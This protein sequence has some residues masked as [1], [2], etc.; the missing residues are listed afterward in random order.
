[1]FFVGIFGIDQRK[2]EIGTYNNAVCPACRAFTRLIIYKSYSCFH[3]F[4]IPT[5]KWNEKYYAES[6]CCGSISELDPVI[7][8]QYEA[9]RL[10]EIKTENLHPAAQSLPYKTCSKCQAKVKREYSFCPHCGQKL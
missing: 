1:M 5:Y 10:P 7:G 2:K 3:I 6:A 9:G 4:F 8:R